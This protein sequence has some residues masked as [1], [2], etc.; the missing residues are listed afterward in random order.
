LGGLRLVPA[1]RRFADRVM[2]RKL[3]RLANQVNSYF[4]EDGRPRR[5]KR[6]QSPQLL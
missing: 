6:R 2:A 3:E 4:G 1:G 5:G